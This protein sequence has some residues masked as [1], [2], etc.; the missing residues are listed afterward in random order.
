MGAAAPAAEPAGLDLSF[1]LG[2]LGG[3]APAAEAED[4]ET[5]TEDAEKAMISKLLGGL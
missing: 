3:A 1:L 5:N 2:G 4:P